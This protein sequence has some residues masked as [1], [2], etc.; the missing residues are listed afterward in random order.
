MA[1][2]SVSG[3]NHSKA[4]KLA[5]TV[6]ARLAGEQAASDTFGIDRR[7]IRGWVKHEDVPTDSWAALDELAGAQLL[8]KVARGEVKNP[9]TL[10]TV[11]GIASR[12]RRYAE[13]IAE[14]KGR[15]DRSVCDCVLPPGW[16]RELHPK[17][18]TPEHERA[19]LDIAVAN[20]SPSRREFVHSI[21]PL[22]ARYIDSI[23]VD[24]KLFP[25]AREPTA[26]ALAGLSIDSSDGSLAQ[27]LQKWI[28]AL[29]DETLAARQALADTA[30]TAYRDAI[31]G[32]LAGRAY[33][34]GPPEPEQA[35]E[36]VE[37]AQ[38]PVERP[39][40]APVPLRRVKPPDDGSMLVDVGQPW[41]W[42][43]LERREW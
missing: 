6:L 31:Q 8:E 21:R 42:H 38:E 43:E 17:A 12:N 11:R 30:H 41:Q 25:E 9:A 7:T 29:D 18:D 20:M 4:V 39:I 14:R 24:S 13:V 22:L 3:R 16:I 36:P 27:R 10:A 35:G 15:Q 32:E 5:A 28:E 23:D 34:D 37:P 19:V 1:V 33:P 2:Q 40:P 26:K